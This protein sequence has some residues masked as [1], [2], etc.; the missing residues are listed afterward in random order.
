MRSV[1]D[2]VEIEVRTPRTHPIPVRT[3][4]F[5][6]GANLDAALNQAYQRRP[7][8][9]GLSIVSAGCSNGAEA[10]TLLSL[11][12][13]TGREAPI[14][15]FGIDGNRRM[16]KA[17]KAGRYTTYISNDLH[18]HFYK[19]GSILREGGFESK[20]K[21]KDHGSGY[22]DINAEPVRD[23]HDLTFVRG[24]IAKTSLPQ[25]DLVMANNVMYWLT[26]DKA[27]QVV[28]NLAAAVAV[29]GILSI[30][31]ARLTPNMRAVGSRDH[32]MRYDT[33]LG[34]TGDMLMSE[35]GFTPLPVAIA[36]TPIVTQ[37]TIFA[38]D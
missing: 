14:T 5:R 24:D 2:T 19:R 18:P 28:H 1:S 32:P 16:I 37:P 13:Q 12:M 27:T 38:R 7:D 3:L 21:W 15:L 20:F 29:D 8:G 4:L 31:G 11:S 6:L 36:D 9:A 26:P 25:A 10:D 30:G 23:G 17:A 22:Y 34:E 33:W 35:Y